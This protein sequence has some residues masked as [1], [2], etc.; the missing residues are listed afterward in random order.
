M[1]ELVLSVLIGL[2]V[3]DLVIGLLHKVKKF[4]DL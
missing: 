3:A 2:S 1:M 4:E